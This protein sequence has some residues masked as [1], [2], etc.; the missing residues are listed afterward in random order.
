MPK[1]ISAH[2]YESEQEKAR[3][4]V[5]SFILFPS[6]LLG[7]VCMVAGGAAMLYQFFSSAYAWTTFAET[8]ALIALGVVIGWAQTRYHRYLLETHPQHFA[9]RLKTFAKTGPKRAR[10]ESGP[11][12]SHPGRQ[13][14]PLA[15]VAGLTVLVGAGVTAWLAGH[16]A[17]VA[18]FVLPWAG[19]FWAKTFFWRSVLPA[20]GKR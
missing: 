12:L 17:L 9:G 14:V 1:I 18:A 10:S 6:S 4:Y 16:T 19:L 3:E 5:R 2:R 8:M 15:Y 13:W 7:L 20:A 11:A